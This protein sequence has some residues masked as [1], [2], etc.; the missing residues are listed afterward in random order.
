MN[1]ISFITGNQ[2]KADYLAKYLGIP[3]DHQKV[4][5]DEIQSLDLREI[6]E[7][8]VRQAYEI[9]GSPVIVEDVSLEFTALG[10]LPGTLI[11]FY[12]D[13]VP[14]ETICRTLDG[15]NRGATARCMFGYYDGE[16]MEFFE[17]K[18]EGTIAEHPEGDNGFGW[19][20][21]FIP[22]G[23]GVTRASLNE[24]DDK[25]T[26]LTIKPFD[27]VKKFLEKLNG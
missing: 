13:E 26:Y 24:A 22:E 12:V 17:G 6:V 11:K 3:V 14:F 1:K 19:D 5:L 25:A 27:K 16:L 20:K 4:E 2:S 10:K 18:L 8:K 15:L 23:F 9:V 7:H 21:I